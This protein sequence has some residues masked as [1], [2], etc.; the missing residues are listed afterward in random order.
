MWWGRARRGSED[1]T[2]DSDTWAERLK[3]MPLT[4]TVSLLLRDEGQVPPVGAQVSFIFEEGTLAGLR[5]DPKGEWQITRRE[6]VDLT[7][8]AAIGIAITRVMVG[9]SG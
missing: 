9:G 2:G 7:G 3:A 6:R 5:T 1:V 4:G 8:T